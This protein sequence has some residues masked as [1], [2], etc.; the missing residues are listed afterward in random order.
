MPTSPRGGINST[1]FPAEFPSSC[2]WR[3]EERLALRLRAS[4]TDT[5]QSSP[6]A[7]GKCLR[8]RALE[9]HLSLGQGTQE[10]LQGTG[11]VEVGAGDRGT[12]L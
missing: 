5:R 1:V 11:P 12:L 8:H 4:C 3:P 6:R 7:A 2:K 10:L 9:F